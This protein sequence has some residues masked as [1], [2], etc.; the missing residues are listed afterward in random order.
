MENLSPENQMN[1]PH[2][3]YGLMLT[4]VGS[5]EAAV[6]LAKVLVEERLAACV[7]T[8]AIESVY[9]WQ[10]EV[11]QD[12]EWQLIIKTSL[13]LQPAIE[14]RLKELHSYELPELLVISVQDGSEAYLSWLG[15]ALQ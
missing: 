1:P 12:A 15:N 14:A 9:R 10:G 11:Q 13:A 7:N 6:T 3:P 5:R 8:F 4:T 2:A